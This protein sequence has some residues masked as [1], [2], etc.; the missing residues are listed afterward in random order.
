MQLGDIQSIH[1]ST[2]AQKSSF[3]YIKPYFTNFTLEFDVYKQID[4]SNSLYIIT[5]DIIIFSTS[6]QLY[7]AD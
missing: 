1:T 5:A 4:C 3:N 7:T 6:E 2:T